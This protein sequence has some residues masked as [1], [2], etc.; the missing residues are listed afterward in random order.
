MV[1]VFF[2]AELVVIF[3]VLFLGKIETRLYRAWLL[4]VISVR[5][6]WMSYCGV[7]LSV[8][9]NVIDIILLLYWLVIMI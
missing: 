3:P 9:S 8:V 5:V 1:H 2:H 7:A 4:R 6:F